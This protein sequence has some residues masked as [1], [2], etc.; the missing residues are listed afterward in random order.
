VPMHRPGGHGDHQDETAPKDEDL[1]HEWFRVT[2][3][4]FEPQNTR[5]HFP[6]RCLGSKFV[7]LLVE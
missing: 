2:T 5:W 3:Y 4:G 1:E 6:I 7:E